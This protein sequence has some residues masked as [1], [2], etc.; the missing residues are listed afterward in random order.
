LG[1]L[2]L[3]MKLKSITIVFILVISIVGVLDLEFNISINGSGKTIYVDDIE[4]EMCYSFI[5]TA[6]DM[7]DPGDL[8]YVYSG[9]YYEPNLEINKS[10]TLMGEDPETTIINAASNHNT[11]AIISSDW[12][13][14]TGFTLVNEM[15]PN[16]I[17]EGAGVKIVSDNVSVSN[18]I[19]QCKTT[20]GIEMESTENNHL[21]SNSMSGKGIVITGEE[22]EHWNTHEIETTNTVMGD[23]V[24][25]LKNQ[26]GGTI[27]PPAGQIILANCTGL[28]VE[29]HDLGAGS[30]GAEIGFSSNNSILNGSMNSNTIYGI[31]LFN[32]HNNTITG[33]HIGSNDLYGCYLEYS[34]NNSIIDNNL[35]GNRKSGIRLFKSDN[36]RVIDNYL[37]GGDIC[38]YLIT[39]DDNLIV[40]NTVF[41]TL[42]GISISGSFNMVLGNNVPQSND[43][44]ILIGG[45]NTTVMDNNV[46]DNLGGYGFMIRGRNNTIMNN[47]VSGNKIGFKL[48]SALWNRI[49]KNI[50]T[51]NTVAGLGL[52]SSHGNTIV[53]NNVS[54]NAKGFHLSGSSNN[55][56]FHNN[57]MENTVQAVDDRNDNLWDNGYPSGGNYWSD[58]EGDDYFRGP[59]QD[60]LGSDGIGDIP[61][62]IDADSED[63]YPLMGPYPYFPNP[64]YIILRQ[65]WNLISIPRDQPDND[66]DTVL[67]PINGN[68]DSVQ[69]FDSNS[70]KDRWKGYHVA[71]PGSLN[72][73]DELENTLGFWINIKNHKKTYFLYNGTDP[74]ENQIITLQK[75]WN[76]VGFP[77]LSNHNRSVGLNNLEFGVQADAIQWFDSS[78]K[79]WHYLD[80]GDHFKVGRGYWIHSTTDCVWEVPL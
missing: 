9:Y 8:I 2:A 71:K 74:V 49:E 69:Y 54:S 39:S 66:L 68:Y 6:I 70:S 1:G 35:N 44:G 36:N 34:N 18:L 41:G 48:E 79:T 14:M 58:Y 63:R 23:P 64:N 19:L 76:L 27:S 43:C 32:S 31:Y 62:D 33:I 65:G 75:G 78:T 57:I 53:K 24:I 46:S 4:D 16:E 15:Q 67:N 5:Q 20:I 73:L 47:N 37:V 61:Y 55:T 17:S 30:I 59:D 40:N 10:V 80:E 7:A 38:I 25:Y 26:V 12:A 21:S 29:N 51:S 22:L 45:T 42:R 60:I 3:K 72:D 13:N 52:S 56:I 11:I 77:S 50:I 28:V